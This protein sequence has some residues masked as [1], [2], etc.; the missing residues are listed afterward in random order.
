MLSLY[1]LD[2][3]AYNTDEANNLQIINPITTQTELSSPSITHLPSDNNMDPFST[4]MEK[5]LDD[6]SLNLATSF[7]NLAT[8]TTTINNN[9]QNSLVTTNNLTPKTDHYTLVDIDISDVSSTN[10]INTIDTQAKDTTLVRTNSTTPITVIEVESDE[11]NRGTCCCCN[12]TNNKESS[13]DIVKPNPNTDIIV[14]DDNDSEEI[15]RNNCCCTVLNCL[16]TLKDMLCP[17][18]NYMCTCTTK[19]EKLEDTDTFEIIENGKTKRQIKNNSYS[20]RTHSITANCS[21]CA[22]A[23][24]VVGA[25]SPLCCGIV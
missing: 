20:T 13:L 18:A 21:T 25:L 9:D 6:S 12:T 5:A 16:S 22:D 1:F 10:T 14:V 15:E 19:Q 17:S 3:F 11:N 8:S 24:K 2:I 23:C 4:E 7:T